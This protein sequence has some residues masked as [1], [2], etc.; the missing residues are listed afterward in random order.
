[1]LSGTAGFFRDR[2]TSTGLLW[3]NRISGLIIL[4]FGLVALTSFFT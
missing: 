1:L 2:I 3:I 4:G